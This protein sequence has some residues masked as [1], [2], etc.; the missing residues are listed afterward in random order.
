[1][2][3][4]APNV[5]R[6]FDA[7]HGPYHA[8]PQRPRAPRPAPAPAT[9]PARE[10]EPAVYEWR[11]RRAEAR[12]KKL[13]WLLFPPRD[14]I[15]AEAKARRLART[16]RELIEREYLA[17]TRSGIPILRHAIR[18]TR[19]APAEARALLPIALEI[20]RRIAATPKC[21]PGRGALLE[22]LWALVEKIDRALQI[23]ALLPIVASEDEAKP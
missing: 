18:D 8:S 6:A 16:P 11:L 2:K 12:A 4:H 21:T 10:L 3:H 9:A 7:A 1:M 15:D 20:E 23:P 5:Y 17:L 14:E 13:R 19:E 22:A